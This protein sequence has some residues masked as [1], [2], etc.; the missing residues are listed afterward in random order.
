MDFNKLIK[1]AGLIFRERIGFSKNL[2]IYGSTIIFSLGLSKFTDAMVVYQISS[3]LSEPAQQK[4]VPSRPR[5]LR[6]KLTEDLTS[7]VGGNLF[8]AVPL[9]EKQLVEE[10]IV[11]EEQKNFSLIGTLEGDPS[12]A[13]AVIRVAG[14]KEPP[15]EYGI[16][17]KIGT[18]RLVWIGR[19]RITVRINGQKVRI[20][21]GE[22]LQEIQSTQTI[23]P[24]PGGNRIV[25]VL[26]RQELKELLG[27]GNEKLF[28]NAAFGPY[29]DPVT[30]KSKGYRLI[31]IPPNHVF[32]KLGAQSGDII[33][34]VNGT[35][36]N[37]N[38]MQS[39]MELYNS[40]GTAS[41]IRL[42]VTRQNKPVQ[43]IFNI[44][45]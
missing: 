37:M 10:Q 22:N 8:Q 44:R 32:A 12:F 13:R 41:Q 39:M 40:L 33:T 18:A 2:V 4:K 11:T 43:F 36:I 20:K 6:P 31:R 27:G 30:K 28:K 5:S 16:G 34:A 45:N 35:P 7:I 24:A 15:K 26:S 3:T 23:A 38:D 42:D 21:V 17:Q 9:E 19:E 14:S 25:K 29:F 1:L